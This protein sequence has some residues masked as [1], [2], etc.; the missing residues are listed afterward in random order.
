M[1][2]DSVRNIF[3]V[4]FLCL[5]GLLAGASYGEN[6]NVGGTLLG[7][8]Y[9]MVG[10]GDANGPK[11]FP[12]EGGLGLALGIDFMIP[13]SADLSIHT[14]VMGE[15][16]NFSGHKIEK[17]APE[18]EGCKVQKWDDDVT[19]NLVYLEFPVLVR[20]HAS[21]TVVLEGG[22]LL[23][24]N[25]VSQYYGPY[26]P[27]DEGGDFNKDWI[28]IGDLTNFVELG[29][30][31]NLVLQMNDNVEMSLRLAYMF[32]DV[33]DSEELDYKLMTQTFKFQGGFTYWFGG[34]LE[35]DAVLP[36][37]D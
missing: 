26:K 21:P 6:F 15:F 8:V 28:D 36:T 7:G 33:L 37:N 24:L 4:R 27:G 30:S 31:A 10:M 1:L 9:N 17:K 25:L 3:S 32:T 18:C 13:F 20:T 23:G 22:P 14:G 29:F 5:W 35:I 11:Y 12:G 19:V 16:R 34:G 2:R